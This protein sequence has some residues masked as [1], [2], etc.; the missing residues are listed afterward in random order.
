MPQIGQAAEKPPDPY[1]PRE[2]AALARVALAQ[3]GP[4][5]EA[6]LRRAASGDRHARVLLAEMV[7]LRDLA[8][9][10][11]AA[12]FAAALAAERELRDLAG[13]NA[14]LRAD[15]EEATRPGRRGRHAG[16]RPPWLRAVRPAAPLAV[17]P[18]GLRLL[19]H[20]AAAK[21]V[22]GSSAIAA[23]A[24]LVIGA[25]VTRTV[26]YQT[27]AP[28]G[29][30]ASR[31]VA[32]YS[33]VRI[34]RDAVSSS[35][36][37][38]TVAQSAGPVPAAVPSPHAS[39]PPSAAPTRSAPAPDPVLDVPRL[40]G[41]GTATRGPLAVR[42]GDQAVTWTLRA[43]DGIMVSA[44]GVPVTSGTLTA[45]QELDLTVFAPLGAGVIYI[46]AGART[47]AVVVSSDLAPAGLLPVP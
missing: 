44:G 12:W 9:K 27:P 19:G 8:A 26:P 10:I 40:L 24:V 4:S 47:W 31:A 11:D 14:R 37:A 20:H 21:A 18:V 29:H 45:G 30:A 41:L 17:V 42:A 33:A 23:S 35:P 1:D 36:A 15:L 22:I 32:P 43:T 6:L 38:R 13:E 46:S 5:R 16:E 2:L 28:A 3:T 25:G 7:V 34:P 39:S